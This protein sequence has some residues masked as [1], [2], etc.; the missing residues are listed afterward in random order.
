MQS[1]TKT[2]I[3]F[4][5]GA[6]IARA[7][8][9]DACGAPYSARHLPH[10]LHTYPAPAPDPAPAAPLPLPPAIVHAY[11]DTWPAAFTRAYRAAFDTLADMAPESPAQARRDIAWHIVCAIIAMRPDTLAAANKYAAAGIAYRLA[12]RAAG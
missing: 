7:P 3:R 4:L 12:C 6:M 8:A 2:A 9:C 1:A 5:P 10:C 11:L